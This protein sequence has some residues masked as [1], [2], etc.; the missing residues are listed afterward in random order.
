[1]NENIIEHETLNEFFKMKLLQRNDETTA[2]SNKLKIAID[3][4]NNLKILS[5][6]NQDEMT[7]LPELREKSETRIVNETIN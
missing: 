2:F 7:R 6:V 3:S 4:S 5:K 1:M